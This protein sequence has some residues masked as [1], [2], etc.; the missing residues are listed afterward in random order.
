MLQAYKEEQE[1]KEEMVLNVSKIVV[2]CHAQNNW[3]HVF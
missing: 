1:M 3:Y 2:G